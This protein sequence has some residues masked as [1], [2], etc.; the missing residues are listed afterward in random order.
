MHKKV[1][2]EEVFLIFFL[3]LGMDWTKIY[4]STFY[5]NPTLLTHPT[6]R[7]REYRRTTVTREKHI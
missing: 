1:T 2:G 7:Q 4:L 3:L 6:L 5:N